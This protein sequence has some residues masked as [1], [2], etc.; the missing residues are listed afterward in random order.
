MALQEKT[1]LILQD[2]G[3]ISQVVSPVAEVRELCMKAGCLMEADQMPKH[4]C[5][6]LQR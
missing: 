4:L 2:G 3:L 1:F 5:K 6:K